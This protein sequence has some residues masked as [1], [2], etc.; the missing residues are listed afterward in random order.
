MI[1][2]L[3]YHPISTVSALVFALAL[4]KGGPAE[5]LGTLAMSADW[6]AE[7]VF[8]QL[9]TFHKL[10]ILPTIGL[11]FLLALALLMLALRYGRL[12]LGASMIVQSVMLSLHSMALSDD[13]PGFY[14]YAASLNV[15]TCIMAACLLIGTLSSWRR[16]QAFAKR[17]AS[18]GR[19]VTV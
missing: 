14:F 6:L 5:R 19:V 16:N 13:N 2:F 15:C 18:S 11:D 7:L 9:S 4:F 12:W 17:P 3:H 10:A 1:R 8:D